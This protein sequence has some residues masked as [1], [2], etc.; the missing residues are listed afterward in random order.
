VNLT[1]GPADITVSLAAADDRA[2]LTARLRI[3]DGSGALLVEKQAG[4]DQPVLDCMASVPLPARALIGTSAGARVELILTDAAGRTESYGTPGGAPWPDGSAVSLTLGP[5][6]DPFALWAASWPGVSALPADAV[7]DSDHDGVADLL[8]FALGSDPG[9]GP[10][11]DVFAARAPQMTA[12]PD[13]SSV[14]LPNGVPNRLSVDF[15]C[16]PSPAFA[17]MGSEFRYGP[18]RLQLEESVDLS[19]WTAVALGDRTLTGEA[20]LIRTPALTEPGRHF[21]LRLTR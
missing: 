9:N 18:W 10:A 14:S 20:H 15:S 21:R 1:A 5:V 19:H 11:A 6:S 3:L 12:G 2:G 13:F 17:K 8:E 7:R 4:C 16:T